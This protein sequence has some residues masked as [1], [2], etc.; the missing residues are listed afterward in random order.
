MKTSPRPV[1]EKKE[2][3]VLWDF[4]LRTD[5]VMPARRPCIVVVNKTE[6]ADVAAPL[7]WRV[8]DK[9]DEKILKYQDHRVE[10]EKLWN[11]KAYVMPVI[12]GSLGATL[13]NFEKHLRYIPGSTIK[14]H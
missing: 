6:H 7:D 1:A 10:I 2:V 11:T 5:K 8:K 13:M 3:K 14:Q 4:E 9:E 12:V